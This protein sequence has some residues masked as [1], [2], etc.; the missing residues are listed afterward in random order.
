MQDSQ[1]WIAEKLTVA[2]RG[3]WESWNERELGGEFYFVSAMI[4]FYK[5]RFINWLY[6]LQRNLEFNNGINCESLCQ[7]PGGNTW[8]FRSMSFKR[9]LWT[10]QLP[11]KQAF[12]HRSC[13]QGIAINMVGISFEQHSF[14][15]WKGK[16]VSSLLTP[17]MRKLKSRKIVKR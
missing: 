1:E 13:S 10:L 17:L 6:N 16:W 5:H 8:S 11:I 7:D 15:T 14:R 2:T 12:S 3:Q 9:S 4:Y